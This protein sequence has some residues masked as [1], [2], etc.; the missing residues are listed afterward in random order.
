MAENLKDKKL[1]DAIVKHRRSIFSHAVAVGIGGIVV[2]G[3]HNYTYHRVMD[4]HDAPAATFNDQHHPRVPYALLPGPGLNVEVCA[5]PDVMEAMQ[6]NPDDP[7][8]QKVGGFCA[9]AKSIVAEW[10]KA[11]DKENSD[12]CIDDYSKLM[13]VPLNKEFRGRFND[14]V[15][16]FAMRRVPT[17]DDADYYKWKVVFKLRAQSDKPSS[18]P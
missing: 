13:I 16:E 17:P 11:C 8:T 12:G 4:R 18:I 7:L 6:D 3:W 5:K 2:A 1:K 10:Y 15:L 14:A 9:D